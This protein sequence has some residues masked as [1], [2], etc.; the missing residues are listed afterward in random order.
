M[1]LNDS[2]TFTVLGLMSGTSLDGLDLACCR[3]KRNEDQWSYDIECA[4]TAAYDEEW[5]ARLAN[6]QKLG[7][8]ELYRLSVDFGRHSA[9]CI[10][11]FIRE[12]QCTPRLIASHGHT[13]FHRPEQGYT[14]QIG[15]GS[16]IAVTTGISTVSDFRSGD[17]AL[18]GQGAPLVP[19]GDRLLF[20]AYDYCLNLGGFSNISFEKDGHRIAHDICPVNIVLNHYARMAGMAYDRDGLLARSGKLIEPLL[21]ELNQLE[22]YRTRGPKSLGREWTEEVFMP[23]CQRYSHHATA[24]L[25]HTLVKH[26]AMQTA[27]SIESSGSP[28]RRLLITGGGA[29]NQWLIHEIANYSACEICIPDAI[30]IN[31]KE[32]LI[33]AFMGLLRALGE[34]NCLASVT[35][36]RYDH[37]SG[38]LYPAMSVPLNVF[39]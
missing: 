24:D 34:I 12:H 22:F 5:S 38:M 39:L 15:E 11:S 13:V 26:M 19:I 17:V 33:F 30:T 28:G 7:G 23:I 31:Y 2:E 10:R 6:A 35:G 14:L 25:L 18:G 9:N 29:H 21:E 32:A 16:V 8:E 4:A 3:F 36:A 20:N 37:S 1:M 27:R